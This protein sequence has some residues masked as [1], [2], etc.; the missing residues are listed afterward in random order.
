MSD[1]LTQKELESYLW[2]AATLLRGLI[3]RPIGSES[4]LRVLAQE[5]RDVGRPQGWRQTQSE[6]RGRPG[7]RTASSSS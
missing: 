7:A 1:R 5:L 6:G 2:G 3:E 4:A